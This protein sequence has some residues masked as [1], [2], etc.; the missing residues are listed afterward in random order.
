VN[1]VNHPPH[2]QG[3]KKKEATKSMIEVI[4]Y[5]PV[6]KGALQ[7]MIEIKVE[8][9]GGFI[10]RDIAYFEKG[11]ERWVSMPSKSYEKDGQK[12]Y[13]PY[14]AFNDQKMDQAF[15]NKVVEAIQ[16]YVKAH[17]VTGKTQSA[18]AEEQVP[19]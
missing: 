12:K 1:V 18:Y 13:F 14:M 17:D 19:F 11:S 7:A 9:W 6:N 4:R 15:K 10:I 2:Y 8:K 16:I 5:K 3:K